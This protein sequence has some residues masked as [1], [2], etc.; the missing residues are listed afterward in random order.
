MSVKLGK[1]SVVTFK[2]DASWI[3]KNRVNEQNGLKGFN[4]GCSVSEE[5]A[6]KEVLRQFDTWRNELN[7]VI[8]STDFG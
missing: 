8:L 7:P 3:E 5:D 6:E 1:S 2:V 4:D